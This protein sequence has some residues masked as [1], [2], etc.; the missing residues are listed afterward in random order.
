MSL[1]RRRVHHLIDQLS[2]EDLQS[3]WTALK[4]F[5]YDAYMLKAIQESKVA[6]NP[7]DTLTR[8]EALELLPLL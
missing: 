3:V 7:G 5:Y 8:E 4:G 2:D 6:L 1:F